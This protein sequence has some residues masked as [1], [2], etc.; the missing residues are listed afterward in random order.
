MENGQEF[1]HR[2]PLAATLGDTAT[3]RGQPKTDK[4]V[5]TKKQK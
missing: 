3:H 5:S 1:F 2:L 4:R